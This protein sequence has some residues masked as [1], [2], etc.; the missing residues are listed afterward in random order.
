VSQHQTVKTTKSGTS[1]TSI[2]NTHTDPTKEALA[3]PRE[4]HQANLDRLQNKKPKKA[5]FFNKEQVLS[6]DKVVDSLEGLE[7]NVTLAKSHG[8][9]VLH[10]TKEVMSQILKDKYPSKVGYIDYKNIRVYE[11]GRFEESV[12]SDALTVNEKLF[13]H[14]KVKLDSSSTVKKGK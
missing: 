7:T 5:E 14:S 12:K 3:K 10:C 6:P 4:K 9:K 13:G 2:S 8:I 1:T 11:E